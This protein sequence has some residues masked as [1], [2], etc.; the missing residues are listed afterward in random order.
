MT[1]LHVTDFY[2][3]GH[4]SVPFCKLCSAEGLDL[5][6]ECPGKIIIMHGDL[7]LTEDGKHINKKHWNKG[8]VPNLQKGN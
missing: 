4:M 1:K 6:K 7:H 2:M 5:I 8:M 3:D